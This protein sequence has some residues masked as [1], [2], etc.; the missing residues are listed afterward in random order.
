[1]VT[2]SGCASVL[3]FNISESS[4]TT[5]FPAPKT[6]SVLRSRQRWVIINIVVLDEAEVSV[7]F[8]EKAAAPPDLLYAKIVLIIVVA[9]EGEV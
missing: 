9:S 7:S 8:N 3:I 1:M 2:S 4:R 5:T 6:V